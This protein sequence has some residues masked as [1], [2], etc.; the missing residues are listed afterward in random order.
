MEM[1][2]DDKEKKL[3][4][5]KDD[6]GGLRRRSKSLVSEEFL[7]EEL[8]LSRSKEVSLALSSVKNASGHGWKQDQR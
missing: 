6:F 1:S 2:F 5:H 3:V 4:V 7:E 8:L